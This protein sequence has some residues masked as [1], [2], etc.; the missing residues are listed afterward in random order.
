MFSYI[1]GLVA[2]VIFF[3]NPLMQMLSTSPP[4]LIRTS[5]PPLNHELL[6]LE[7]PNETSLCKLDAYQIHVFSR[8]PLVLYIESFLTPDERQHLL[9][10][11]CVPIMHHVCWHNL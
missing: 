7:S 3:Y 2:C 9:E 8:E 1:I 6:A 11:R 5:R 10:I 4:R